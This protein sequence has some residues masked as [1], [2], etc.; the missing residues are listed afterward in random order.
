M[1]AK[2]TL[3]SE[4]YGDEHFEY[5]TLK[6]GQEGFDRLMIACNKQYK[7]DKIDRSLV[8]KGSN[9]EIYRSWGDLPQ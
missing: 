7:E 5:D 1:K 3:S 6:E 2:I 8:L 9:G 4:V